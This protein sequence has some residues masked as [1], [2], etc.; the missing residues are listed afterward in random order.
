MFIRRFTAPGE[1]IRTIHAALDKG[2]N[3]IDTTPVW[4]NSGN[5]AV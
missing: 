3:L 2:I 4:S 5:L 1:S